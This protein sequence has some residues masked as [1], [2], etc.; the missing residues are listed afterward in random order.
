MQDSHCG[1]FSYCRAQALGSQ[2]LVIAA[3]RLC[4]WVHG[5]SCSE[6][7]GIFLDQG[8]SLCPLHW[9]VE[10]CPLCCLGSLVPSL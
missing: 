3:C 9:Q 5:V 8:L 7:W 6:T 4:S 10:S 1:T 2:A